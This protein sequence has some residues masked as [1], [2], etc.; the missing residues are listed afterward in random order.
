MKIIISGGGT[1]G[2]IFP[3]VAIAEALQEQSPDVEILFVGALGKMEMEKIP[4]A[5]YKIEGLW[6]SGFSRKLNLELL[7]FPF[8]IIASWW[9]SR[10]ILKRFNPDAV[11]GVGGYASGVLVKVAA[12]WGIPALVHE[13]NSF[14]G[15]TN[16]LLGK[17]VQKICVAY[18]NMERFFPKDKIIFTGNPIRKD[19]SQNRNDRGLGLN[20]FGFDMDKKMLLIVG[21]SLGSRTINDSV[22]AGLEMLVKADIQVLWQCGKLYYDEFKPQADRYSNV[23]LLAFIDKIDLAYSAADLVVSRAGALA[24][25]ELCVLKKAVILVPSPNVTD[26]HQTANAMVL[27]EKQAAI[28]I[29]DKDAKQNLV[30]AAVELIFDAAKLS[31]LSEN[32]DRL[33]VQDAA[34]KIAALLIGIIG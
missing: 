23:K 22:A 17:S 30:R 9:K 1:G 12:S 8:K 18:P 34:Q 5:G 25:S 21:G 20:H 31:E 29:K 7:K 11:V 27:V 10:Q 19:I 28:L 16:R 4:A 3:A 6:I 32:I 33:A 15:A 2:H 14:A 26:D 13:Q 24:I